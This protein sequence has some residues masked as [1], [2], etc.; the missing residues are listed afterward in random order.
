[1]ISLEQTAKKEEVLTL[2]RT[3]STNSESSLSPRN[4]GGVD[5]FPTPPLQIEDSECFIPNLVTSKSSSENGS[6]KQ[7]FYHQSHASSHVIPRYNNLTL[8]IDQVPEQVQIS[9]LM[10]AEE[11]KSLLSR[12]GSVKDVQI[13]KKRVGSSQKCKVHAIATCFQ[14]NI[15]DKQRKWGHPF[16]GTGKQVPAKFNKKEQ[17]I[18]L[19][20]RMHDPESGMHNAIK[21]VMCK[22]I[23]LLPKKTRRPISKDLDDQRQTQEMTSHRNFDYKTQP[24]RM[25]PKHPRSYNQHDCRPPF[26]DGYRNGSRGSTQFKGKTRG[27]HRYQRQ[28]VPN[29]KHNSPKIVGGVFHYSI[30]SSYNRSI[31]DPHF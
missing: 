16:F 4:H 31:N 9:L 6:D 5:P 20:V 29:D 19:F 11:L 15:C 7:P 21:L 1:M 14:K 8:F 18:T 2:L 28:M 10:T 22:Y 3:P 23:C 12:Y 30:H 24:N 17:H 13:Y 26:R 27:Q 25:K